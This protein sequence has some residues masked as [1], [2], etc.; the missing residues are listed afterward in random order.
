MHRSF[1]ATF[2]LIHAF[3]LQLS[4]CYKLRFPETPTRSCARRLGGRNP[5]SR[6]HAEI[7]TCSARERSNKPRGSRSPTFC[8][9]SKSCIQVFFANKA[10]LDFFT[11]LRFL[12]CPVYC[13]SV[14][15]RNAPWNRIMGYARNDRNITYR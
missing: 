2:L 9:A 6:G 8:V 12:H 4:V 15:P 11:L 3:L 5:L 14:R 1:A 7:S 13:T 10:I